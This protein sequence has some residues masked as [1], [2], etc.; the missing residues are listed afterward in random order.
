MKYRSIYDIVE[1]K[2]YTGYNYKEINEF[3]ENRLSW[4]SDSMYWEDDNPPL[5]LVVKFNNGEASEILIPGNAM[6]KFDDGDYGIIEGYDFIRL[7]KK[8]KEDE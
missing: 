8:V 2:I 7:F 5:D 6:V 4:E 3:C 1:A